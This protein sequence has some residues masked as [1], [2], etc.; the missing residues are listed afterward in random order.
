MTGPPTRT[1]TY[2]AEAFRSYCQR[3]FETPLQYEFDSVALV[4]GILGEGYQSL[5][6]MNESEAWTYLNNIT[7]AAGAFVGEILVRNCGGTWACTGDTK[8]LQDWLVHVPGPG[9]TMQ[10]VP[11]FSAV[12]SFLQKGPTQTLLAVVAPFLTT[13]GTWARTPRRTT[14]RKAKAATR[15]R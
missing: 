13:K 4:D 15:A 1:F 2:E 9:A 14:K 5:K 7:L 8:R 3:A 6:S 12:Y 11:V 10:A